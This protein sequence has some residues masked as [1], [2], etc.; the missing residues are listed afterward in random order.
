MKNYLLLFILLS[1]YG[2]L[3]AQVVGYNGIFLGDS[4][5]E[6]K[7]K[8]N[9][10]NIV[11]QEGHISVGIGKSKTFPTKNSE[12]WLDSEYIVDDT[13]FNRSFVYLNNGSIPY[14][15]RPYGY[16]KPE[17][18]NNEPIIGITIKD[19]KIGNSNR[20]GSL[21]WDIQYLF[22]DNDILYEILVI[23]LKE[24]SNLILPALKEKYTSFKYLHMN[25]DE[26]FTQGEFVIQYV[27][28]E[29]C[30][31]YLNRERRDDF[32]KRQYLSKV[33]TENMNID[34]L[35]NSFLF[36]SDI[37]FED[38]LKIVQERIK[39]NSEEEYEE[40]E[41]E[42]YVIKNNEGQFCIQYKGY[43]I[44]LLSNNLWPI[45]TKSINES[46]TSKIKSIIVRNRSF[47]KSNDLLLFMFN[48]SNKLISTYINYNLLLPYDSNSINKSLTYKY[49]TPTEE[50]DL[51][52]NKV[53]N[54]HSTNN[55]I[56]YI[57]N[58]KVLRMVRSEILTSY[59]G[60]LYSHEKEKLDESINNTKS[61]F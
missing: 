33:K 13:S 49:G 36:E 56:D 32:Y 12:I 15:R 34:I 40:K 4:Y 58:A 27:S 35:T 5:S 8:L 30:I 19:I 53:Y 57:F 6:V 29:N 50:I 47:D 11:Y 18:N 59:L 21:Y 20:N 48:D 41:I 2:T 52:D 17:V 16:Y 61:K 25:Y 37:T 51:Y 31:D 7:T 54:F 23:R 44:S 55:S 28:N 10:D 60:L 46:F 42:V 26:V 43:N 22:D 3:S 1:L 38:V 39:T 9:E 14:F 45:P 24:K